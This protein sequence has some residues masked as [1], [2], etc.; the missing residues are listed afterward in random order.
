[1]IVTA[2]ELA[3]DSKGI[4]DKVIHHGEEVDIQ[5]HGKTVATIRP[6]V[7][8][9]GKE[10]RRLLDGLEWTEAERKAIKEAMDAAGQV[11][12]YAGRD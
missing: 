8:V 12:G 2:T 1:M 3:N 7:G 5:R 9:S 4:L 6:K 11:I 10:L